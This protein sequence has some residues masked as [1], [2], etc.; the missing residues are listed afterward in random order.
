MWVCLYEYDYQRLVDIATCDE[1][2]DGTSVEGG[3]NK[4]M[5]AYLDYHSNEVFV[6]SREGGEEDAMFKDTVA[7]DSL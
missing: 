7:V 2:E 1:A 3:F 5:H 6:D 4:M